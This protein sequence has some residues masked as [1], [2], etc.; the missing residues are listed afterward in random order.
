[1]TTASKPV[2]EV[3]APQRIRALLGLRELLLNGA[4]RPGE[5][6]FEVPLSEQLGVSRTPLRLAL[7][8]LEHEGLLC[9]RPHGGFVMRQFTAKEAI[10][11]IELRGVL[12]GTA[13]R[14]AA[15]RLVDP[16]RL[17]PLRGCLAEL[18]ELV[19]GR[20]EPA[21][22]VFPEYVALNERFHDEL[23]QLA[24]SAPLRRSLHHATSLP[25]ASPNAFVQVQAELPIARQ[26]LIVAQEQHRAVVEAIATGEGSRAESVARE[27][28]RL[29]RRNLEAALRAGRDLDGVPGAALLELAVDERRAQAADA[30]ADGTPADGALADGADGRATAAS[31]EGTDAI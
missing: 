2:A 3:P 30:R 24:D 19:Y 5:R 8:S 9:E 21:K 14:F 7:T 1:M 12:E 13:A 28:A 4:F 6:L 10:D 26:V 29:A 20:D 17:D 11:A 25:F 16:A 18:D 15:E 31:T 27:H 23:A 22:A